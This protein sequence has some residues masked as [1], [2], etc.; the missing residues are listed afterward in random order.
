VRDGRP[1]VEQLEGHPH[2]L[3]HVHLARGAAD[4]VGVEER[5]LVEAHHGDGVREV[6]GEG[7][8]VGVVD[9]CAGEDLAA[10]R[11]RLPRHARSPSTTAVKP[12]A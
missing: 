9:H 7:R 2:P 10:A 5:A 12:V 1:V 6:V 4:H 11:R 3:A 8:V